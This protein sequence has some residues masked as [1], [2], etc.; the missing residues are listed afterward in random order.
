MIEKLKKSKKGFTLVELIVVIA[1]IG[2]LAAVL[3]PQYIQ[4]IEK[5]REGT[6]VNAVEELFHSVE[7]AAATTGTTS[8]TVNISVDDKDNYKLKY[9]FSDGMAANMKTEL[10]NIT[11]SGKYTMKSTVGKDFS[12][13][14]TLST[15]GA[16]WTKRSGIGSNF[17]AIS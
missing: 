4:Y 16:T 15:S 2:V 5:S 6:D 11:A 9:S 13:T 1:I 8:G 3:V 7:I 10:A 14:I 12:G 17:S